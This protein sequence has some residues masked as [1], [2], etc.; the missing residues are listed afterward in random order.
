MDNGLE[1]SL[2]PQQT[3]TPAPAVGIPVTEI[4]EQKKGKFDFLKNLFNRK[5]EEPIAVGSGMAEQLPYSGPQLDSGTPNATDFETASTATVEMG[6]RADATATLDDLTAQMS[7]Q[8]TSPM[9][10]IPPMP[11]ENPAAATTPDAPSPTSNPDI[12]P[13]T[14][15]TEKVA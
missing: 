10:G 11:M 9:P 5:K 7:A 12:P 6:T 15:P 8:A 14:P 3:E 4:S 2:P 13:T 1:G